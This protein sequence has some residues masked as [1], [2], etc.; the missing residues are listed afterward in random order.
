MSIEK[1]GEVIFKPVIE[2]FDQNLKLQSEFMVKYFEPG[3]QIRVIEGKYK[4]ETGIVVSIESRLVSLALAQTNREVKIFANY[5]KLRS[6]IDTGVGVLFN[7]KSA[8]AAND[9]VSYD[10]NKYVGVIL[11]VHEDFLKILNND[12]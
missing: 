11:Q 7:N 5:L 10:N 6:E 8:Y 9:L 4:G 3:D 1:N 2:G 12:N